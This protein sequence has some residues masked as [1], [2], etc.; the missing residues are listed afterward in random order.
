MQQKKESEVGEDTENQASTKLSS[1]SESLLV[2]DVITTP[3]APSQPSQ[4]KP[5]SASTTTRAEDDDGQLS[6]EELTRIADALKTISTDSAL[7]DVKETFKELKENR[8]S[9]IQVMIINFRTLKN[10]SN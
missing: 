6:N 1:T 3:S 8:Q 4:A 2:S 5:Q 9:Y 7:S 10:I